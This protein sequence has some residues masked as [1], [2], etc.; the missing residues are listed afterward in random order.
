MKNDTNLFK[1]TDIHTDNI[2]TY[3]DNI[4][5]PMLNEEDKWMLN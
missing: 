1:T 2:S 3:L 4:E 5:I